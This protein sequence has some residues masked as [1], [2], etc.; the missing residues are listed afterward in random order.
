MSIDCW[1]RW[2]S[3]GPNSVASSFRTLGWSSSGPKALEGFKPSV[4][5]GRTDHFVGFVV[6][7]LN[8]ALT[9]PTKQIVL[10]SNRAGLCMSFIFPANL[11]S[12]LRKS[13]TGI[14]RLHWNESARKIMALFVLRKLILQSR[15]RSHP[16]GGGGV[17]RG[18]GARMMSDFWSDPSSTSILYVC[19]QRRLWRD[20]AGSPGPSLVADVIST[21]WLKWVAPD[22]IQNYLNRRHCKHHPILPI[23]MKYCWKGLKYMWFHPLVL[24]HSYSDM[25]CSVSTPCGGVIIIQGT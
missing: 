4:F 3:T 23:R 10:Q 20:C 15:M 21:I 18:T 2:A 9:S 24:I 19:E 17:G 25:Y 6:R 12:Y 7:R 16:V 11:P 1:K 8:Y 13:L 22:L 5:A 14:Q